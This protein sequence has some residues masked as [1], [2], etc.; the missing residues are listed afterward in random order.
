MH[1]LL[2]FMNGLPDDIVVLPT[3]LAN[4]TNQLPDAD[5]REFFN[6]S[7]DPL[8][9]KEID[10]FRPMTTGQV[11]LIYYEQAPYPTMKNGTK[12][13]TLQHNYRYELSLDPAQMQKKGYGPARIW[14]FPIAI[15]SDGGKQANVSFDGITLK[16][17]SMPSGS[18][19]RKSISLPPYA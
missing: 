2:S 10:E 17:G 19:T 11:S 13:E 18:T 15:S 9:G 4:G 7:K 5:L 3:S 12:L 14:K 6:V 16:K 8:T 1:Y